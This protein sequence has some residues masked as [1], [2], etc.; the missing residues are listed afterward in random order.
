MK[1]RWSARESGCK[2]S[3][4]APTNDVILTTTTRA[5][6]TVTFNRPD[7]LNAFD[8]GLYRAVAAALHEASIDD[9]VSAVV[10][11]GAG[12]AFSAG[13]DLDEMALLAT[14][15]S[16]DSGFPDFLDA[17]QS[18]DKPLLC[19]VNGLGIGIGFTLL[20]HCDIVVVSTDARFRVPFA[21]LG[22]PPEA[23]SSLLFPQRMGWQR[24][25]QVLFTG[26]WVS[27]DEAVEWGLALETV[28]PDQVVAR[29]QEL[30]ERIA[31]SPLA[32]LR[33]IKT[34]MLAGQ[35]DAISAAR[36]HEDA[37]FAELLD[38]AATLGALD[39]FDE[40]GDV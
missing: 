31:T 12:R 19:A 13:Q 9:D 20:A 40:S 24:A 36:A 5:V 23:A 6:R 30:A 26:D 2:D 34:A 8:T 29:A 22:V 32:A 15:A 38:S 11:T 39:R 7:K 28:T 21:P 27:A 14:G 18:F 16:S 10:L 17:L 35:G 25:A 4:M 3:T 1:R 33:A 37:A